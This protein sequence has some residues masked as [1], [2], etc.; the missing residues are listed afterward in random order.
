MGKNGPPQKPHLSHR[1][2]QENE[3]AMDRPRMQFITRH[4]RKEPFHEVS[5]ID[6]PQPKSDTSD[7]DLRFSPII[8]GRR[9][10][11]QNPFDHIYQI[12]KFT[13]IRIVG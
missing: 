10:L 13:I 12:A 8:D 2:T 11:H 3:T 7:A 9:S 4:D 6:L 5:E 1:N